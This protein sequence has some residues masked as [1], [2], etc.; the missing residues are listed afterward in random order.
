MT[1]KKPINKTDLAKALKAGQITFKDSKRK[2]RKGF[3]VRITPS[4]TYQS[5][6]YP[7][8]NDHLSDEPILEYTKHVETSDSA[9]VWQAVANENYAIGGIPCWIRDSISHLE[10]SIYWQLVHYQMIWGNVARPSFKT[11]S[12]NLGCRY[13][14]IQRGVARLEEVGA[15]ERVKTHAGRRPNHFKVLLFSQIEPQ[16]AL[17]RGK[18]EFVEATGDVIEATAENTRDDSPVIQKTKPLKGRVGPAPAD[19]ARST[20][21][22]KKSATVFQTI[23][24]ASNS[25]HKKIAQ[26]KANSRPGVVRTFHLREVSNEKISMLINE[27]EFLA[28]NW[29]IAK[30]IANTSGKIDYENL[31]ILPANEYEDTGLILHCQQF[32]T[33]QK[34]DVTNLPKALD[35]TLTNYCLVHQEVAKDLSYELD[36]LQRQK[37]DEEHK[38]LEMRTQAEEGLAEV[39]KK[40]LW[41]SNQLATAHQFLLHTVPNFVDLEGSWGSMNNLFYELGAGGKEN[42]R[43]PKFGL[44]VANIVKVVEDLIEQLLALENSNEKDYSRDYLLNKWYKDGGTPYPPIN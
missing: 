28:K 10:V 22:K 4:N 2:T 21:R 25:R 37:T 7:G 15:I 12:R 32:L 5:E 43:L 33:S 6:T 27:I 9:T 38:A 36:V 44:E 3:E 11:L 39:S 1:N 13:R 8:F 29:E 30:T 35:L 40:R 14:S 18:K 24:E 41:I 42:A 26:S 34:F 16:P 31:T 20:P 23:G 17:T 19:A